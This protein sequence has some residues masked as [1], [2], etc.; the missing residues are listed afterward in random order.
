MCYI[1]HHQETTMQY[2]RIKITPDCFVKPEIKYVFYCDLFLT[3]T[4]ILQYNWGFFFQEMLQD[5]K[6][7]VKYTYL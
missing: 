5:C 4:C 7:N 1:L 3:D 2:R 6:I